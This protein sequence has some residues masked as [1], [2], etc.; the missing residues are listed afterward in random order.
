ME[1]KK[2]S[3]EKLK[4]QTQGFMWGSIIL[5]FVVIFS[6]ISFIEAFYK[7]NNQGMI[8]TLFMFSISVLGMIEFD[9]LNSINYTMLEL[10]HIQKQNTALMYEFKCNKERQSLQSNTI[11]KEI[12]KLGSLEQK[13]VRDYLNK[14]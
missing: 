7:H 10:R 8:A 3:D 1:I 12:E 5:F 9:I 14:K 6:M 2:I 11:I 13:K 4:K